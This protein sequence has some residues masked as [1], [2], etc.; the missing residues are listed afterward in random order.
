MPTSGG[1]LGEI[2]EGLLQ[3]AIA[4]LG[5]EWETQPLAAKVQEAKTRLGLVKD[6]QQTANVALQNHQ[7][8]FN[9]L[10][11]TERELPGSS[12]LAPTP[13]LSQKRVFDLMKT[14]QMDAEMGGPLYS[15]QSSMG[16]ERSQDVPQGT[17]KFRDAA[18]LRQTLE[19]MDLNSANLMLGELVSINPRNAQLVD[20]AVNRFYEAGDD[21]RRLEL[22]STIYDALPASAR[23]GQNDQGESTVTGI[24]QR[25]AET[26]EAIRQAAIAL[27]NQKVAQSPKKAFNMKSFKTA[28]HKGLENVMMFGPNQTRIDPFTGQLISNWHVMERNKGWGVKI[29]GAVDVD[30]EAIWRGNVMDKYSRPYRNSDGEYVGGYINKRFE[31]DRNVPETNNYQLKPGERNKPYVPAYR[32]MEARLQDLRSKGDDPRGREF[33][34]TEKPFDWGTEGRTFAPFNLKKASKK[35]VS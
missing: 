5:P 29:P 35:K 4:N 27:A 26:N 2:Q 7:E 34:N 30:F 24:E 19:G 12:N 1:M 10:Q 18:E 8:R 22:A 11:E 33:V 16:L 25:V 6:I 32:N 13:V 17:S 20:D 3:E 15:P 31:V 23:S 28:Q 9:D 14:A 21:Q